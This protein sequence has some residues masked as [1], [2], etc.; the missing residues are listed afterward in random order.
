MTHI[1][2]LTEE[3]ESPFFFSITGNPYGSSQSLDEENLNRILI[4]AFK[5]LSAS[6]ERS[7]SSSSNE[8][9]DLSHFKQRKARN[10]MR[11]VFGPFLYLNENTLKSDF[12]FLETLE[13]SGLP[14]SLKGISNDLFTDLLAFYRFAFG[15]KVAT[16]RVTFNNRRFSWYKKYVFSEASK[17]FMKQFFVVPGSKSLPQKTFSS[18]DDPESEALFRS[19][20]EELKEIESSIDSNS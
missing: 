13:Q 20:L 12:L 1:K 10:L 11:S 16:S 19:I 7:S 3:T 9:K 15:D 8:V 17:D 4:K 18:H 2:I 5:D 6:P 14:R